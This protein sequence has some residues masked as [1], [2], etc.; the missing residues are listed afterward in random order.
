MTLLFLTASL[1]EVFSFPLTL[2]TL[3]HRR[4]SYVDFIMNNRLL[5]GPATYKKNNVFKL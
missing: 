1:A 4:H 5:C 3:T 2:I